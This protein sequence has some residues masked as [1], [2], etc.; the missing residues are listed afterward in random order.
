MH[1]G[2]LMFAQLMGHMP[3]MVSERC[4]AR[5]SGNREV[6]SLTCM[7]QYLYII[8]HGYVDVQRLYRLHQAGSFFVTRPKRNVDAQ[9]SCSHPTDRS[10]GVICD[11]TPVLQ[12]YQSA[13]DHQETFRTPLQGSRDQQA[14]A[15][16]P[17][18]HGT[19]GL[20]HLCS[21]QGQMAGGAVFS[22]DQNA[23]ARKGILRNL[24]KRSQVENLDRRA[25]AR[26]D[27]QEA[28]QRL[29][30]PVGNATDFEH[31]PIPENPHMYSAFAQVHGSR[32]GTRRQP[33]DSAVKALGQA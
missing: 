12:R 4:V 11:Q 14:L 21:V 9:R 7:G 25:G 28:P 2:T 32:I 29:S 10:T 26:R 3:P 19:A 24:G 6:Q 22:L 5:Y 20:E 18:Q 33:T 31:Q 8:D 27:P 16:H 30:Q 1:T 17:Q 15:V 23:F 13:K